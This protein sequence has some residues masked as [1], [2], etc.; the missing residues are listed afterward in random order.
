VEEGGRALREKVRGM[1]E[2]R[3]RA[4]ELHRKGLTPREVRRRLL[5]LEDGMFYVTGGH[6]S[7]QNVIDNILAKD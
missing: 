3:D 7:K 1:E 6:F 4:L 5:G 2:L